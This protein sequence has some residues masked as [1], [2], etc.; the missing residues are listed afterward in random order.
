M[1][2]QKLTAGCLRKRELSARVNCA[3]MIE[4][5]AAFVAVPVD[6]QSRRRGECREGY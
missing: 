6:A 5:L 2:E 4:I 3:E 1:S